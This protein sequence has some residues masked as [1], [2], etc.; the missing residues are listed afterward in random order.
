[1][2][3]LGH[4]MLTLLMLEMEYSGFGD[5]YHAYQSDALAP[6]VASASAG[7]ALAVLDRQHALL[8][9]R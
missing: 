1:M 6:K 4:N 7:M 3:S 5:Q 9:Q 2:A 8:L